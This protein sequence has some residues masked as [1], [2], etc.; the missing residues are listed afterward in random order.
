MVILRLIKRGGYETK[1]FNMH[2]QIIMQAR[3][4][5]STKETL[6]NSY[7]FL[8]VLQT[9]YVHHW[10]DPKGNGVFCFPETLSVSRGEARGNIKVG[11]IIHLHDLIMC[12]SEVHVVVS[13][14]S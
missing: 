13:L 4:L 12:E 5:E 10:T 11:W 3:G 9:S 14:G 1:C 7:S 6:E 8:K 2:H